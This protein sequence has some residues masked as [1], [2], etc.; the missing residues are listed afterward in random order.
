LPARTQIRFPI[1]CRYLNYR[2]PNGRIILLPLIHVELISETETLTTIG[3][4]DSGATSSFIPYEIAD[5]LGLIPEN[6]KSI[7]V[8]T[9]GGGADFFPV[10]LKRLSLLLSGKIFSDFPNIVM[11]VPSQK[12]RD[13][14]YV[15]LG[16][17]SVFRRF[18]ITFKENIKK[19]IV[20]HHKWAR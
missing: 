7:P 14:P 19:F 8:E 12:D 18:Y 20:Q 6:P 5:I 1:T 15:I 11:L 16:R 17:D 13:L 3:L 2:L 9:A 4:L 10:K